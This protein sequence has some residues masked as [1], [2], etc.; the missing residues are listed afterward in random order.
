RALR[1][2]D[3]GAERPAVG[4][5]PQGSELLCV[6]ELGQSAIECAQWPVSNLASS[7]QDKAVAESHRWLLAEF[8]ESGLDNVGVLNCEMFVIEQHR[9]RQP[10][11]L[12]GQAIRRAKYPACLHEDDLGHPGTTSDERLS[13]IDLSRIVA[14][15]EANEDI[16]VNLSFDRAIAM[17][18]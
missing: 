15:N 16:R 14:G 9:K 10:K 3:R 17:A 2:G 7:G 1:G 6:A 5:F 4:P 8:C 11:L 18:H 12:R 13:E